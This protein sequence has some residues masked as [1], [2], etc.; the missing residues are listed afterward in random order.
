MEEEEEEKDGVEMAALH[1]YHVLR[2]D[3]DEHYV[4]DECFYGEG[5][6][7]IEWY[8][9]L[10]ERT[11]GVHRNGNMVDKTFYLKKREFLK[12]RKGVKPEWKR[13]PLRALDEWMSDIEN[14]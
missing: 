10:R 8:D 5:A 13:W 11:H 7:R 12:K 14:E 4:D 1:C 2:G 6:E 3:Q 9:A